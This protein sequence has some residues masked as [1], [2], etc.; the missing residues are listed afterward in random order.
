MYGTVLVTGG[1]GFIGTRLCH[2]L[3]DEGYA[4]RCVDALSGRYAPSTGRAAAPALVER[5]VEGAAEPAHAR[6]AL[7]SCSHRAHPCT[8][9]RASCQRPSTRRPRRSTRTRRASSRPSAPCSA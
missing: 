7:A 2:A 3:V 6:A 4:V 9:T 5:G 1:L 8:A